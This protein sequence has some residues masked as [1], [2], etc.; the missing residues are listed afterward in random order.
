MPAPEDHRTSPGPAGRTPETAQAIYQKILDLLSYAA[1]LGDTELLT[2]HIRLPFAF[3]TEGGEFALRTEPELI[4]YC[5]SFTETLRH[6]GAT[7]YIRIA[8]EA[9]WLAPDRIE[10]VHYSHTIRRAERL[11]APYASRMIVEQKDG[12]WAVTRA[13]HKLTNDRVPITI[14]KPAASGE[15]PPPPFNV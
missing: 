12:V 2:R 1:L 5:L 14:P 15:T 9:R 4:A 3:A 10:G 8:R 6:L 7:D 11:V 13:N